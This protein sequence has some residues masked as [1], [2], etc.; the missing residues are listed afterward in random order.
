MIE[1]EKAKALLIA[2]S[3]LEW[4][5]VLVGSLGEPRADCKTQIF[6]FHLIST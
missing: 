6:W 2:K 4:E 5:L 1:K 3:Y